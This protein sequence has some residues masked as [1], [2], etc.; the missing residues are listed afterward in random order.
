MDDVFPKKHFGVFQNVVVLCENLRLE[1]IDLMPQLEESATY[2]AE[3]RSI[4]DPKL[5]NVLDGLPGTLEESIHE[6]AT[7][8]FLAVSSLYSACI[9]NHASVSVMLNEGADRP[10]KSEDLCIDA[11]L[12]DD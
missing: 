12:I 4:N 7:A 3:K 11:E 6:K 9:G 10:Y 1:L 8:A 2:L 5:H